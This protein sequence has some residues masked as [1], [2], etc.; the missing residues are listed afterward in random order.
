MLDYI[1]FIIILMLVAAFVNSDSVMTI[2][3]M[4]IGIIILGLWWNRH[5]VKR[6]KV[7]RKLDDHA[8]L[9]QPSELTLEIKNTS[10]LP[11]IWLE[12][13]E[14]LPLNVRNTAIQNY[15]I[16]LPPKGKQ[17]LT[18]PLF[19]QKRGF[20]KIG[21][22][23]IASG[24]LMGIAHSAE[25]YFEPDDLTVYPHIVPLENLGLPSRSPFGSIRHKDPIFEDP[26]RIY[27]KR[28]YQVGDSLKRIDWKS[29][30]AVGKLQVKKFEPSITMETLLILD[31]DIASFDIQKL[32]D[33]SELAITCAASV[34]YWCNARKMPVGLITNGLDPLNN[35]ALPNQLVAQRGEG[36]VMLILEVLARVTAGKTTSL[37]AI[38]S[39]AMARSSW[40]TTLLIITPQYSPSLL[41][42]MLQAKSQGLNVVL[43]L[44]GFSPII[45]QVRSECHH[46]GFTFYNIQQLIDIEMAQGTKK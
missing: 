21:P 39:G 31:L 18:Y 32:Y 13:H 41:D 29:S 22:T 3:Y 28:D 26:S 36:H 30:A 37:S 6:I 2:F 11:V 14:S 15:V 23:S 8:F 40:G 46:Y 5:A 9:R 19:P 12:I 27:G 7:T 33:Y 42:Q 38:L 35:N 34:A 17:K 1:P 10:L 43:M 4:I 20:Y 24:D 45:S 44:I 25:I 16:S